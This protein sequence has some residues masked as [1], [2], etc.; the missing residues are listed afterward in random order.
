MALIEIQFSDPV[1]FQIVAAQVVRS[2]FPRAF[3]PELGPDHLIERIDAGPASFPPAGDPVLAL[4][5]ELLFKIPFSIVH[6]SFA[7]ARAAGSLQPPVTQALPCMLWLGLSGGQPATQIVWRLAR[8]EVS[9]TFRPALSQGSIPLGNLGVTAAVLGM[10]AGDGVV[11]VRLGTQE[12]DSLQGAVTNRIGGADWGQFVEGQVFADSLADQ[13]NAAVDDAVADSSDPV[14]EV[15]SHAVGHWGA[16]PL[17]AYASVDIVAVDAID[18]IDADVPVAIYA[19]TGIQANVLLEQL[20]LQTRITWSAHD[21]IT[22]ISAGAI[23]VVEDKVSEKILEKL[24]PP[25]GQVELER[26]DDHVVYQNTRD[27]AQLSTAL[28]KATVSQASIGSD[29]LIATGAVTVY[30][31]PTA[32]FTLEDQHWKTGA[33]CHSRRWT[34]E[35]HPAV[36][37][38]FGIDRFIDCSFVPRPQLTRR[39]SGRPVSRGPA[40]DRATR[41]RISLS[42]FRRLACAPRVKDRRPTSIPISV[43]AGSISDRCRRARIPPATRSR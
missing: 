1:F 13:M 4:P 35:F 15:T 16:S 26:G 28:F 24:K 7:D 27:L 17:A 40:L 19:A 38:I 34:A 30:P 23:G 31:P 37:S 36:V 29:G 25:P 12:Q 11:A 42:R 39:A 32:F 14:I 41:Q 2:S 21:F 33:D 18:V 9:G 43:C 3:F 8:L 20:I 22:T 6:T 10:A 5:G